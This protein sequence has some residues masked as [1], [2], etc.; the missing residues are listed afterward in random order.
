MNKDDMQLTQS[1]YSRTAELLPER[2]SEV[3]LNSF[4]T[5][6]PA[7]TSSLALRPFQNP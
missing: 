4:K 7:R 3:Q 6:R 2:L 1:R 5:S